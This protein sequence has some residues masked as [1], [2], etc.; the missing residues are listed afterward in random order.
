M[1]RVVIVIVAVSLV[2]ACSDSTPAGQADASRIDSVIKRDG[3]GLVDV[4]NPVVDA[5]QSADQ[6]QQKDHGGS[7][8][9]QQVKKLDAAP[10]ID[11]GQCAGAPNAKW[12]TECFQR[13]SQP[14]DCVRAKANCCGCNSGGRQLPINKQYTTAWGQKVNCKGPPPSCLMVVL[15]GSCSA[16]NTSH[17]LDCVKNKCVIDCS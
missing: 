4:A 13:C 7:K 12:P 14:S 8:Q 3:P 2:G 17:P 9:D 11:A 10:P 15:C 1:K 16:G 6:A 5:P